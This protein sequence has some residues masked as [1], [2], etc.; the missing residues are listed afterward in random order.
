M[1]VMEYELPKRTVGCAPFLQRMGWERVHPAQ[2][3]SLHLEHLQIL[4]YPVEY[5]TQGVEHS[6]DYR[7][8]TPLHG[9][10]ADLQPYPEKEILRNSNHQE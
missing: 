6:L 7:A 1:E 3:F 10:M 8:E 2:N 4:K 9:L 5:P